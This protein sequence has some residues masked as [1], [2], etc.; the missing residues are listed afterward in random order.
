MVF[1]FL[2]KWA[3]HKLGDWKVDHG[4]ANERTRN[5]LADII[6]FG[7]HH[8][9]PVIHHPTHIPNDDNTSS[10]LW[11][12][13]RSVPKEITRKTNSRSMG[14]EH[15]CYFCSALLLQIDFAE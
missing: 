1:G 9:A 11:L 3:L 6:G 5:F 14:K 15:T 7:A 8:I 13:V 4:G 10:A 2:S 12:A